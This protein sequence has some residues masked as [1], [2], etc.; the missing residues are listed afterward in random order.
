MAYRTEAEPRRGV[1]LDVMHGVR[2]VVANNPDPMTYHGTNSY[3]IDTPEGL[4]ILDP[5]PDQHDHIA[6]IV[7]AGG[8]AATAIL[9]THGHHDHCAGAARLQAAIGA[10]I[11]GYQ[12]FGSPEVTINRPLAE[13]SVI[14]GMRA[15]FAPGHA[16][17][18]LCFARDD[19]VVFSGD[20]VM[21]WSS[22]V[23]PY[24]SGSMSLFLDSLRRLQDRNDRLYLP[25]HGPRLDDPSAFIADLIANRLKRERE[26][27]NAVATGLGSPAQIV[28]ALYGNRGER[29]VRASEQNVRSHLAKLLSEGKVSEDN[30]IW[31]AEPFPAARP[32]KAWL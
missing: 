13:G 12:P 4:M 27:L 24:P 3:I 28:A 23:V 21:A 10:P 2:R 9:L 11:Y 32:P 18:H 8:H 26:I 5:G 16:S 14:G 22:S 7:D 6:A 19:G 1:A 31:R 15:L 20:Q 17:D 29:L 30:G 25:G